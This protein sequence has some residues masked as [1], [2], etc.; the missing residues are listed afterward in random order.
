MEVSVAKE[1]DIIRLVNGKAY[2]SGDLLYINKAVMKA[3]P[4]SISQFRVIQKHADVFEIEVVA[5]VGSVDRAEERF[6]ELMRK[7]LGDNIQIHFKRVPTI[8]ADPSGKLR[9]FISEIDKS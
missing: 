7:Q 6:K 8:E 2:M 9:Y 5:G 3:Y 1:S 4:S